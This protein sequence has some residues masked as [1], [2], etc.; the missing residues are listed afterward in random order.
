MS[1]KLVYTTSS[2][3]AHEKLIAANMSKVNPFAAIN[4]MHEAAQ[5]LTPSEVAAEILDREK[6]EANHCQQKNTWGETCLTRLGNN[7]CVNAFG[8]MEL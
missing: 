5:W 6:W 3:T 4:R 7:V 2:L 8:H 1:D